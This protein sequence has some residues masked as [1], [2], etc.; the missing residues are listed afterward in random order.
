MKAWLL[1]CGVLLA[2]C[3]GERNAT[4]AAPDRH[5]ENPAAPAT[6]GP[7]P[8]AALSASVESGCLTDCQGATTPALVTALQARARDAQRCYD[9][10]LKRDPATAGRIV[11]GL[12]ITGDGAVCATRIVDRQIGDAELGECI[13][14][15]FLGLKLPHP[16]GGCID[17]ALPLRFV[18]QA[19]A[20]APDGGS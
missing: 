8:P 12:Q 7:E 3:S 1:L 9:A 14:E 17:V 10:A 16:D 11:I 15:I 2:A 20:G 5:P 4:P 18:S 19:D 6:H 13:R